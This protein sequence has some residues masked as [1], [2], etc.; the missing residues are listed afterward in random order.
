[1]IVLDVFV[2]NKTQR[3][4]SYSPKVRELFSKGT[5]GNELN[6]LLGFENIRFVL[7]DVSMFITDKNDE[8]LR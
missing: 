4:G 6:V 1:M 8:I 5:I 2:G 3:Y 7:F